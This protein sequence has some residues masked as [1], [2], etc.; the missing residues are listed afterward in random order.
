MLVVL[1]TIGTSFTKVYKYTK[2]FLRTWKK[3]EILHTV[4][5]DGSIY[6]N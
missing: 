5:L 2:I 3:N 6:L 1:V 4:R